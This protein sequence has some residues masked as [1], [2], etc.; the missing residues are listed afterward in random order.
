MRFESLTMSRTETRRKHFDASER[1]HE[2]IPR[3]RPLQAF[4]FRC[5]EM[6]TRCTKK[7]TTIDSDRCDT[8]SDAGVRELNDASHEFATQWGRKS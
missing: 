2:S 5:S 7:K 3:H 6:L 8:A 4:R 1:T